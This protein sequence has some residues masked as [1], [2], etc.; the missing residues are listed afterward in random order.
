MSFITLFI[1]S[2]F[3]KY[4]LTIVIYRITIFIYFN[5]FIF[6]IFGIW[7]I[8]IFFII[9]LIFSFSHCHIL[10]LLKLF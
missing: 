3:H 10:E 5:F 7:I 8:H 4:I 2:T 6:N 1:I 9:F